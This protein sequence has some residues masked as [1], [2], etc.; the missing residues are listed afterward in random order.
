MIRPLL[1]TLSALFFGHRKQASGNTGK[2][3]NA[4]FF[5]AGSL[6]DRQQASRSLKQFNCF[7]PPGRVD[8]AHPAPPAYPVPGAPPTA[9]TPRSQDG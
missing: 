6:L 8:G 2:H 5:D 9:G 3:S 4:L 1:A 7:L